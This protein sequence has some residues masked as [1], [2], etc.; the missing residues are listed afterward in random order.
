MEPHNKETLLSKVGDVPDR[1]RKKK[2]IDYD[3]TYLSF[4][5]AMLAV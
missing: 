5:V 4:T 1:K 2:S 3:E